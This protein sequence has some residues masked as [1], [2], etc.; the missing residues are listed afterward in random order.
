M[1][2]DAAAATTTIILL[3][4]CSTINIY[5]STPFSGHVSKDSLHESSRGLRR[6]VIGPRFG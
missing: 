4:P 3:L 6:F 1:S 2:V 5:S